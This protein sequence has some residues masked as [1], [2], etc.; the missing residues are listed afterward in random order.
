MSQGVLKFSDLSVPQI[1]ARTREIVIAMDDNDNFPT[2]SPALATVTSSVNLLESKYNLSRRK[3]KALTDAMKLQL[4]SHRAL[5]VLV[6]AY[7]QQA[8]GG[9]AIIIQ[10]AAIEVKGMPTPAKLLGKIQNVKGTP[11]EI[12]GA[13]HLSWQSEQT[14]RTYVIQISTDNI[15]WT[16]REES[17][18]KAEVLITGLVT[19]SFSYY[20]V[21]GINAAGRGAYSNP[22]RVGAG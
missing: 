19:E 21:A 10:S 22:V 16:D 7:V 13:T 5:M 12:I 17:P 14:A 11:S 18:T 6:L 1:V 4:K 9:D 8:S 15:T 3:G 2:P 20:R